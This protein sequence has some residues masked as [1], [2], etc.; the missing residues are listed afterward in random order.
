MLVFIF[1]KDVFV[2]KD[3]YLTKLVFFSPTKGE[4]LSTFG[5]Y[6]SV[7]LENEH[8][9]KICICNDSIHTPCHSDTGMG[10]RRD[11]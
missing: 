7:T 2:T 9:K 5:S 10:G 3:E 4:E 1:F 6:T 11:F 8:L